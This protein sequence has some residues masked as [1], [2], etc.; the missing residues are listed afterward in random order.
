[1]QSCNANLEADQLSTYGSKCKQ[2]CSPTNE[3]E[4]VVSMQSC[5]PNL[6]ADQLSTYVVPYK[7]F[8]ILVIIELFGISPTI[9]STT[10]PSLNIRRVG[11]PLT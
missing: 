7:C 6:E 2:I 8:S 11:S 10:S 3:A 1:M 5:I 4:L 9:L